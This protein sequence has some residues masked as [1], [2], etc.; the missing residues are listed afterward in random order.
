MIS[1]WMKQHSITIHAGYIDQNGNK[2]NRQQREMKLPDPVLEFDHV[3]WPDADDIATNLKQCFQSPTPIQSATWPLLLSGLNVIG[4][5][6]T[7]SGKTLAFLLPAIVHMRAQPRCKQP[8]V[9]IMLPTRELA[10]QVENEI[11]KF[12][13]G[14]KHVC[15][16]GGASEADQLRK[17]RGGVEILVATPGRLLDFLSRK[18]VNLGMVCLIHL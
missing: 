11:R 4:I 16:Y 9:L 12:A 14:V 15:V 7:G 10:L 5:A 18:L 1:Q 2:S 8:K 13:K 3:R 6:K 17:I